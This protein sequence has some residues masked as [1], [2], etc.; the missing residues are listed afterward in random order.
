MFEE[1][2]KDIYLLKIPFGGAWTGV[3]LIKGQKSIN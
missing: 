2:V 3:M 1:I